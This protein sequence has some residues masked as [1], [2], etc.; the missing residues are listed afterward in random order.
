MNRSELQP[1]G[2]RRCAAT[3]PPGDT[4]SRRR[5]VARRILRLRHDVR[6][7]RRLS[8]AL[9]ALLL[10]GLAG[11]GVARWAHSEEAVT[12]GRGVAGVERY[13]PSART[14]S[15]GVVV[16]LPEGYVPPAPPKDEPVV[17]ET[18][19][20]ELLGEGAA[21]YY[22]DA[23]EGRSTAS[24]QPYR[25]DG[26]TAAHRSLPFGS[27]VR[28]TNLSNGRAVVVRVNDRGPFAAGR[29]I[30]LSR[31]AAAHIGLL[32]RGHGKVRLE[33]VE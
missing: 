9:S 2:D 27:R 4:A 18:L 32:A 8:A 31:A 24:G 25:A 28:V 26:L 22:H 33:L 6:L 14:Q 7:Y 1:S 30:D 23:L 16:E 10:L 21:S 20:R 13:D 5:R 3:D 11:F 29:V 15:D 17:G 19:V 12:L